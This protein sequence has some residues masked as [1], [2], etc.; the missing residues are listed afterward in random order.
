M[1]V[2]PLAKAIDVVGVAGQFWI[3]AIA[4]NNQMIYKYWDGT[5][6]QP[7]QTGWEPLGGNF[8]SPPAAS[9]RY[10]NY[11][12][13][14]SN[15]DIIGVSSTG[16]LLHKYWDGSEW[17]PSQ[18]EWDV[19]GWLPVPFAH[20]PAITGIDGPNLVDIVAVGNDG[21]A[22]HKYLNESGWQP[23]EANWEV[24]GGSITGEFALAGFN[25]LQLHIFGIG[26]D[27]RVAHKFWDGTAWQP[28]QTGWEDAGGK[29]DNIAAAGT[30]SDI[31]I[32]MF[33]VGVSGGILHK[34]LPFLGGAHVRLGLGSSRQR[35]FRLSGG[36]QRD[37]RRCSL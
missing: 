9:V 29:I 10:F 20:P 37:S 21:Q 1:A 33:G 5:Q 25:G 17:Q 16:Y 32:D 13:G 7:S 14:P 23:S 4:A 2:A 31:Q 27:S 15:V 34:S 30:S 3:F 35:Q 18:M 28:S 26:A 12:P 19:L 22:Y 11:P 36:P 24:L 6:W 8:I